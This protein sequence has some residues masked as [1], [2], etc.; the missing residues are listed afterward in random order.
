MSVPEN[1][2]GGPPPILL[3]D[4]P[5]AREALDAGNDP[6]EVAAQHPT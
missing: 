5:A 6:T 3:S 1:L 4:E 2:L